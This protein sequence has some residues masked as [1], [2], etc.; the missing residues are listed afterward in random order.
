M[1]SVNPSGI[2]IPLEVA[3]V[4]VIIMALVA[5]FLCTSNLPQTKKKAR[6]TAKLNKTTYHETI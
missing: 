2:Q 5:T 4:C 1:N 6:K 3:L